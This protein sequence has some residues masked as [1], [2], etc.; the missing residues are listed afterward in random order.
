MEYRHL[1]NTGLRASVIGLGCEGFSEDGYT[2]AARL[3]DR[4]EELGINYFDL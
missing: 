2:M 3:F 4:A 1:G